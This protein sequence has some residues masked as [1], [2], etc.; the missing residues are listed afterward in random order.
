VR[1]GGVW[2]RVRVADNDTPFGLF[3]NSDE[4]AW[5]RGVRYDCLEGEAKNNKHMLLFL[6]DFSSHLYFCYRYAFVLNL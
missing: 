6:R 5:L 3:L 4:P 2:R 1:V